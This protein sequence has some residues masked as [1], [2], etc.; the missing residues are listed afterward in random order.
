MARASIMVFEM[1]LAAGLLA[2]ALS[3]MVFWAA[4]DWFGTVAG[5][6]ALMLV[7]LRSQRAGALRAGDHGHRRFA[8]LSGQ[9]LCVLSLREGAHAAALAAAGVLAGLLVATKHSGILLAPML[10]LLI[11]WELVDCPGGT[12]GQAGG[13]GSPER[14]RPSS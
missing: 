6:V 12:R 1:R 14:S 10:L 13:R 9:H 7:S 11:A 2:L 3:L 8:V 5:L 4:R